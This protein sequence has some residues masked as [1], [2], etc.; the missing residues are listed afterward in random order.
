MRIAVVGPTFPY[1]GGIAQHTTELALALAARGHAVHL[2]S[3]RRQYPD[4][5]YPGQQRIDEPEGSVFPATRYPLSWNRPDS[6]WR[7]GRRLRRDVDLVVLVLVTPVQ[8]PALAVLRRAVGPSA[9]VLALCHNVLPHERRAVDSVLVKAVL[10]SV[11][12]VVVHSQEERGRA[13]G[14]T[15]APVVV[16]SMPPFGVG[17]SVVGQDLP[18]PLRP[19]LRRLLFFGLV[20]PYKGLDVLLRA[21]AEGPTDVSLVVA[22]EFWG[23]AGPTAAMVE[24]LGIAHR[25]ELREGYVDAKEVPALLAACDALVL[26]YRASTSSQNVVLAHRYGVPVVATQVGTMA[27]H[28]RDGVDGLLCPPDD[29]AGLA[30][31]L[32]RLYQPGALQRLRR[33]IT[34]FDDEAAWDRYTASFAPPVLSTDPADS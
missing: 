6:W 19:V 30:D 1:K 8:A 23:G 7:L 17:R 25:V 28:V 22:G 31:A 5:L 27:D 33:G 21:L 26:P 13:A 9:R 15:S 16:A 10:G 29:V 34:A 14:L 11:D 18:D 3:W 20:R 4:A 12:Q 24:E 2:E 32:R